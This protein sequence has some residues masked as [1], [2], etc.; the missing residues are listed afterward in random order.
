MINTFL[1]GNNYPIYDIEEN[2]DKLVLY[3]KSKV[4]ECE[5]PHCHQVSNSY[6]STYIRIIQDTPIHCKQTWLNVSTYKFYCLNEKCECKT[7]VEQLPFAKCSQ[8]KTDVLIS[9]ILGISIFLSNSC[10]SLILSLIG[11]KVSAD[12]I[13]NIYDKIEIIDNPNVEEIGVDDVATRKGMKYATAIYDLKDHHLI[14]LLEG[15]ESK[16]LEDWLL[17]HKKVKIVAR[18][19]ASSYAS[20]INK[21]LPN[22][23]QVADRY[24]LFENL[25]GK[26]KDIF[27]EELPEEIY[28]K[29]GKILDEPPKKVKDLY[30]DESVLKEL[31]YDNSPPI[32][33]NGNE[34]IYDNK[35]HDLTSK[36][37]IRNK[38][39]RMK[40]KQLIIK[41]QKRWNELNNKDYSVIVDEFKISL[42]TA[43]KYINMTNTDID[44]LDEITIYK[45]RKTLLDDYDNIIY[46]M[47]K[48][49]FDFKTIYSYVHYKG[50]DG[51]NH[52]LEG[53]IYL[54]NKNNF[55]NNPTKSITNVKMIYPKDII[56]IKRTNILK[57]ILT[58]NPK[59][60][61]DKM[62]EDNIDIIKE[63]YP[64]VENIGQVFKDF[65]S[66]IM[67][68]EPD[69][70][71]QFLDIYKDTE[72]KSFCESIKKDIA[73]VKNAI[74]YEISS[75]F[76]EGNNNK[77]KL[78]KRIVYG[79][80]KLVNLFQKCY[81]AFLATKDDFSLFDL[82]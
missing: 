2:D 35:T 40:K 62:I 55:P 20:A 12:T 22:C 63:T 33:D 51:N 44:K 76:V 9:M 73:P 57:Y 16:T 37:Y 25:L 79:K 19:R 54:I 36:Q 5:C 65:Y 24:H 70:I 10:A 18:D 75:G 74:S 17:N 68:D 59:T 78:I 42:L 56:V 8:V 69:L 29:N 15:R 80:S 21:I 28:I 58:I 67:S 47:L 60:K 52:T 41:I 38:Q 61:K 46:K 49:N 13:K 26:L 64:I 39:S 43:K 1:F 4:H 81:V 7:F 53:H 14:A 77:F 23:I 71:D 32:D 31:K 45:K 50:F 6:H 66:V 3:L 82:I 72:I 34:I 48:D 27:K 30:V 11:I